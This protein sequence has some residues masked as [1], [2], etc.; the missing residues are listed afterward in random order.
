MTREA[1]DNDARFGLA[2]ALMLDGKMLQ[3]LST[4]DA[5]LSESPANGEKVA[6][7]A[8]LFIATEH[9]TAGKSLFEMLIAR[10][11]DQVDFRRQYADSLAAKKL[12]RSAYRQYQAIAGLPS[13]EVVGLSGMARMALALDDYPQARAALDTLTEKYG[14]SSAVAAISSA[15]TDRQHGEINTSF[16]FNNNSDQLASGG[17]SNHQELAD[18]SRTKS[19]W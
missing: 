15:Y 11:P 5:L 6:S 2:F 16:I 12:Y 17:V 14:R 4:Y 3:S 8:K 1:Q 19:Q 18:N 7:D 10:F 9:Y 13:A